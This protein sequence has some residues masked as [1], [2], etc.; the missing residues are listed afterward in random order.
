MVPLAYEARR[1]TVL[2]AC[3]TPGP[4]LLAGDPSREILSS[5]PPLP[6]RV[7]RRRSAMQGKVPDRRNPVQYRILMTGISASYA[8]MAW[9]PGEECVGHW[10]PVSWAERAPPQVL[11]L[12]RSY[13][14]Q[15]GPKGAAVELRRLADGEGQEVQLRLLPRLDLVNVDEVVDDGAVGQGNDRAD[16]RRRHQAPVDRIATRKIEHHPVKRVVLRPKRR[17]CCQYKATKVGRP[18]LRRPLCPSWRP[19]IVL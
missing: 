15:P 11:T 13:S 6:G 9:N 19:W 17:A 16:A 18:Q 7:L 1:V 12:N 5:P 3:P 2:S 8:E 14:T 10:P 4:D